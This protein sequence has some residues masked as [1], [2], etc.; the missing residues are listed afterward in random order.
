MVEFWVDAVEAGA[1]AETSWVGAEGI[2]D[3]TEPLLSARPPSESKK[4]SRKKREV[5]PKA[6]KE[7]M[8]RV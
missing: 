7:R 4:I 8:G 3:G 5:A 6:A 1:G 2:C